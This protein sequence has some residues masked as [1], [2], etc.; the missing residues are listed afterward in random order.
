MERKTVEVGLYGV[1]CTILSAGARALVVDP[2]A[3]PGRI[4]ALL[5]RD[6]L[7][8][9]A[10][11]LTHAHFDH[12]GGV[13][14]LLAEFP[15]LPV[16]VGAPDLAVYDHPFNQLAPE[17]PRQARPA[18]L[19]AVGTRGDLPEFASDG[20]FEEMQVLE[21]PGHT[22]GGVCYLFPAERLLLSGDT[23]FA[24]SV[25]RTDFPGGDMATLRAS[26]RKLAALPDDV[27]VVPGHGAFTTIGAERR[28]NP[29]LNL[30]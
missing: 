6:G 20:P 29:F 26:L 10:V 23:L 9:A 17:Y 4:L 19:R 18:T 14:G 15:D 3:E 5:A 28:G 22:P 30:R 21:T 25:G 16:L 24:G 2:G 27:T 8:P 7:V 13:P 1:N 11:L 12:I